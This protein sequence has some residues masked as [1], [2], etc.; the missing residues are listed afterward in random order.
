MNENKNWSDLGDDFA[1]L[2]NDALTKGDFTGI[3]DLVTDTVECA[4]NE[5][6]KQTQNV[7]KEFQATNYTSNASCNKTQQ[8]VNQQRQK[9]VLIQQD[10]RKKLPKVNIRKVGKVSGILFTVFG[11]IGLGFSLLGLIGSLLFVIVSGGPTPAILFAAVLV[12]LFGWMIGHGC[13][14]Q[15]RVLRAE[16]FAKLSG[17]NRYVT[18]ENLA[19]HMGKS[20]RAIIN[21]VKKMLK[22]GMFPEGHLDEKQ[23]C[24]ILDN[25]VYKTYLQTEKA[26][27]LRENEEKV[28]VKEEPKNDRNHLSELEQM[29]QE[30]NDCIRKLRDLNDA[31][32]GEVISNKLFRLENLLKEIFAQVKEHPEKMQEM[33]KFMDYYLPTTLKLVEAYAE[34]DDVS[35]PGDDILKAKEQI[36][37]TLET[38]NS[39]FNEL[40]NNLFRDRVFDVTTD[41]QVLQT[42][43]S[44]E[45]LTKSD[46]E[47]VPVSR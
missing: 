4:I 1:N 38:I 6:K 3:G 39:A 47:K 18:I 35:E 23:T 8:Y 40:L 42:L 19:S 37:N 29:V 44:K 7:M 36:E 2:V 9:Q 27:Q 24:L 22:I 11:G 20:K 15:G 14:L 28:T 12:L 45:G 33:H 46:F 10:V 26:R 30:G 5:A 32:E 21:D 13:K 16:R 25:E 17:Q 31:I 43:L 41:A 34:F